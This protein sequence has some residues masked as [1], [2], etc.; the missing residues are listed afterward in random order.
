MLNFWFV[1]VPVDFISYL[2]M[3]LKPNPQALLPFLLEIRINRTKIELFSN[4]DQQKSLYQFPAVLILC[5]SFAT[6]FSCP[7]SSMDS[8][9]SP[10]LCPSFHTVYGLLWLLP[11]WKHNI[12][13]SSAL[14]TC[15]CSSVAWAVRPFKTWVSVILSCRGST[16][17]AD[18][19]TELQ[20]EQLML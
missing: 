1:S 16:Y 17:H 8:N 2:T 5:L 13:S 10:E 14:L 20:R 4:Q 7:C 12:A 18:M 11:H 19:H 6:V 3:K 15:V 9:L